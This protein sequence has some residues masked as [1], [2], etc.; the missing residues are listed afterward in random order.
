[1][2]VTIRGH[3]S[4]LTL[5]RR[6]LPNDSNRIY[7]RTRLTVVTA[8]RHMPNGHSIELVT[9]AINDTAAVE[10]DNQF[11]LMGYSTL[12]DDFVQG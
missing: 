11:G 1:M 10:L 7:G 3:E 2:Q 12:I 6:L 5:R 8:V 4:I 9:I